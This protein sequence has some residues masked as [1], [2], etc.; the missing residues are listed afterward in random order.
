MH[1]RNNIPV[2]PHVIGDEFLF[3]R[4][5][6]PFEEKIRERK[7]EKQERRNENNNT[8]PPNY[9]LDQSGWKIFF[10]FFRIFCFSI[11]VSRFTFFQRIAIVLPPSDHFSIVS[12]VS[13]VELPSLKF[14]TIHEKKSQKW[15]LKLRFEQLLQIYNILQQHICRRSIYSWINVLSPCWNYSLYLRTVFW[16]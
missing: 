2:L 7:N 13:K 5:Y 16:I 4:L 3:L 8:V 1:T 6:F 9:H 15:L 10:D 12:C 11:H 14:Q